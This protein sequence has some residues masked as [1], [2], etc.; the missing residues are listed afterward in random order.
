MLLPHVSSTSATVVL[1]AL[2]GLG[3]DVGLFSTGSASEPWPLLAYEHLTRSL[4]TCAA[5]DA[6]FFTVDGV[7]SIAPLLRPA[8]VLL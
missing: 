1:L 6:A 8:D 2:A 7:I 3:L 5:L 4:A